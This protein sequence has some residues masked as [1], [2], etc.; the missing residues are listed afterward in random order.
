MLTNQTL[1]SYT[2]A[3]K[4][5]FFK[6]IVRKYPEYER[7]RKYLEIDY[8]TPNEFISLGTASLM[9]KAFKS[10]VAAVWTKFGT[11][12]ILKNF[13]NRN[14][15][16]ITNIKNR[17]GYWHSLNIQKYLPETDEYICDDPHGNY[18]TN[19]KDLNGKSLHFKAQFLVKINLG[20]PIYL[21]TNI[22]KNIN[23]DLLDLLQNIQ[24]YRIDL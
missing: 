1:Y 22:I 19:Y 12:E 13:L 16:I 10:T 21:N 15:I 14:W 7:L 6:K 17:S 18:F 4:A 9:S 5:T 2:Q 3:N 24:H 8:P 20:N 11:E 23:W